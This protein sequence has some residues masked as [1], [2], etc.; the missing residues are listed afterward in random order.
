MN[1]RKTWGD[2]MMKKKGFIL[3]K[4]G[5]ILPALIMSMAVSFCG[6]A[7]D[8]GSM[9][10]G[11][12][13]D[14]PASVLHGLVRIGLTDPVSTMDVQ[15][16]TE[17]YMIPLNI[18]ERLFDIKADADGNSEVVNGL[19]RDYT[20]SEDGRTFLFTLRDDAYFADGTQVKAS[21][22][23]FTFSRMLS[24]KESV[25]T[26]F[27]DM[28]LG[29]DAVMRGEADRPEGIRV[30]DDAQIQIELKEPFAGYIHL[31]AAPSCSILSESFVNEAGDSY[32]SL[33]ETTIGSGPYMVTEFSKERIMLEKN[34]YYHCH[35]GEEL[36]VSRAEV[37][38][39]PPALMDQTFRE[40]GLD[41]LDLNNI[42]PDAA[43][44]YFTSKEWGSHLI[45]RSRVEIQ[46]L[47]MNVD[48]GVLK[49]VRIRKAV[50]MAINR[51]RILEELYG[52]IGGILT[53][54]IFPKGLIGYCE[55]NQGWLKYDPEEAKRL[56]SE[57]PGADEITLELAVNSQSNT[58][59]L[60][61]ME[62]IRQDLSAAGL[63]TMIVSYD[64]DS[65]MYLRKAG[66]LMAYSSEWSADYN[67]PDNFIYTF[68]GNREKTQYRS[69]NYANE[70]IFRRINGARAI[71]DE[72][73]RMAEY[74]DLERVLIQDEAVWVP[75]LSSDHFFVLGSRLESF[76]PFWAG[77]S[78]MYLRDVSLKEENR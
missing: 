57:V 56:I 10:E 3:H 39:L 43:Q 35:E 14:G 66:E 32:G 77:W 23:A 1:G 42:N 41:L 48:E 16:T 19:A 6:C 20:V 60:T 45:A 24:M 59:R 72:E 51:D 17:D 58:R 31:L 47:M 36:S 11:V 7:A 12:T 5:F 76:S 55:E 78:S 49:D 34:P 44:E 38:I 21:D 64:S 27:A 61:M 65:F 63:N 67:D 29:A 25:Q 53:D 18:Y 4:L 74:A 28:I 46:Y 37:L 68:F 69:G 15:K 30:L 54:G 75:L 13:V 62:M 52:G 26:D 73:A 8:S 70:E 2:R 9:T 22:V 40:G 71:Q 33:A 50:Q